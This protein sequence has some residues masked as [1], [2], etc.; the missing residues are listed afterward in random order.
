MRVTRNIKKETNSINIAP[1]LMKSA[2][3]RIIGIAKLPTSDA[4]VKNFA[5]FIHLK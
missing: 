3:L 1:V 2:C 5:A 4:P